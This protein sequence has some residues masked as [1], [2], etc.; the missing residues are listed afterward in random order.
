MPASRPSNDNES[1]ALL[2]NAYVDGELDVARSL[3]V[4]RQI[5]ADPALA[6]QA[7]NVIALRTALR[8]KVSPETVSPQLQQRIRASIG[9]V[10]RR[11]RRPTWAA[12]AASVLIALMVGTG[13]TYFALQQGQ[14][15]E[16]PVEVADAHMR[17]LV[18]AKP[19][20]VASSERHVV[21][22]WFAG[23]LPYAPK[24]V[25]LSSEGFPLAGAR[26]DVIDTN[27]VAALVYNRRL[28]LISLFSRPVPGARSAALQQRT[29]KGY[30]LVSWTDNGTEYWA[31][32]DLNAEELKSFAELFRKTS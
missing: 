12:L 6:V 21:R 3:E 14:R 13:G 1:A 18:A 7:A 16:T 9:A 8:E 28:H 2:V 29:L 19:F 25:D 5:E 22:P 31:I 11:E 27:P 32:S 23:K 15:D 24:V 4:K 17:A 30:N 10:D 20:D 26:V